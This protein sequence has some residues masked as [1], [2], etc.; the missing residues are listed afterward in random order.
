MSE[1][2]ELPKYMCHKEV[3]AL[4]I[5]EIKKHPDGTATIVPDEPGQH[6]V[7]VSDKYMEKHDPQVGGYYVLYFDGYESFSPAK[8][9]EDGYTLVKPGKTHNSGGLLS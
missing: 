7:G 4:K 3:W 9:F 8:A 5:R 6:P 2:R 1:E